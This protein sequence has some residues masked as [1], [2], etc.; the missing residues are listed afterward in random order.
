MTPLLPDKSHAPAP[1]FGHAGVPALIADLGEAAVWSFLE[2]FTARIE[3]DHTRAAYVRVVGRFLRWIDEHGLPLKEVRP[4]H[5]AAY[6]KELGR[7]V[8]V[9]SVKQSL[10]AIRSLFDHLVV[11]QVV[12][13][14]PAASVRGP[15]HV[16]TA[17]KTPV[18][19]EDEARHL[20]DSIDTSTVVGLRDKAIIG[21]MVY[22]FARVGAAVGLKVEDY[23]PQGK[24]WF[25]T[26]H[27]KRG[28]VHRMP[29]HHKL[30][31]M[32]D[33]YIEAAGIEGDHKGPLFRT[34]A[35]RSQ[36]LTANPLSTRDAWAMV[37]RRA[38]DAGLETRIGCHTF[39]ATGITAYLSNGSTLEKAQQMA[40]HASAKT[41]KLYDRRSDQ[42][43]LDE[44]ERIAI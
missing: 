37:R 14:N 2:F 9:P 31:E 13:L 12:P 25:L 32:L 5:V 10:A 38:K 18:L 17:G 19:D 11:S 30:E 6:L 28:R 21:V 15:S 3:N 42:V 26:L 29:C 7:S 8:S 44:V 27:E 43:T 33:R 36:S 22:T 23:F 1:A 24:R 35:G 20:L 40:G 41:T 4:P 34:A 39:R 16:V